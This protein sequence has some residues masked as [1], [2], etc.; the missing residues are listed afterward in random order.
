[1]SDVT[2]GITDLLVAASIG[3]FNGVGSTGWSIVINKLPST[4]E[5]II[6]IRETGGKAPEPRLLLDYPSVQV[7]VRGGESDYQVARDKSQA[8]KDVLLGLP[9]QDLDGDRWVA[10]NMIS[11]VTPLQ[12]DQL[13]RPMFSVNFALIIE[14]ATN[15]LTHREP[16]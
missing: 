14:P 11:D 3:D 15:S 6:M 13:Q 2:Q 10:I 12:S 9:S 4:P 8:V 16:V 1:M 5:R 7:I